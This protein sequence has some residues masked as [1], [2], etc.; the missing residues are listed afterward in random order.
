MCINSYYSVQ[1]ELR[2][3]P[4]GDLAQQAL[5]GHHADSPDVDFFVILALEHHLRGVVEG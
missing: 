5:V 3:D 4:E 2:V 1:V